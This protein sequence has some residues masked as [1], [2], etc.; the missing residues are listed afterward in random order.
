M[1]PTLSNRARNG[2][3][4]RMPS[5]WRGLVGAWSP[6]LGVQGSRL[7]DLSF[8]GN[9]G[10]LTNMD[11]ATD[12]A[13]GERGYALD[14]DGSNDYVDLGD[15]DVTSGSI[16]VW[17][18]IRNTQTMNQG[19]LTKRG[20]DDT[21]L[22]FQVGGVAN[23]GKYRLIFEESSSYYFVDTQ[24]FGTGVWVHVVGTVK[25][26]VEM[27]IY[28]N[29]QQ[30]ASDNT[31]GNCSTNN[32]NWKLGALSEG[33]GI[34]EGDTKF[35]GR[36]AE[37]LLYDRVLTSG[38]VRALYLAGP[39]GIFQRR[40]INPVTAAAAPAGNDGAAV[41]HYLQQMGVYG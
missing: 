33:S 9:H 38:D 30:E 36:I 23:T 1:T 24:D 17:A 8:G 27:V 31:I 5:L 39:G 10:D 15:I 4:A 22:P 12:W 19:V 14:F 21:D 6:V 37:A 26:G 41:Y 32:F 29:G 18:N 40:R 35:D 2:S 25:S 34:E 28:A 11:P 3:Q 7:F 20:A 16:S 13:V